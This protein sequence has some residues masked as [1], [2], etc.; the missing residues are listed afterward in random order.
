MNNGCHFRSNT[1]HS[2]YLKI[3]IDNFLRAKDD[4]ENLQTENKD[5]NLIDKYAK[6]ESIITTYLTSVV[7]AEMSFEAFLYD[8]GARY[9]SDK[10]ILEH[11][12]KLSPVSKALLYPKL[13]LT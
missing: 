7:F 5:K 13:I 6:N 9:L 11:L 12:E 8:F 10:Y 2:L 4:Y 3:A 1:F